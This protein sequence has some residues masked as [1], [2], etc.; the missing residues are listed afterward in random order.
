[1]ADLL[2]CLLA[3]ALAISAKEV[4][5]DLFLALQVGSGLLLLCFGFKI[6]TNLSS[7]KVEQRKTQN[8]ILKLVLQGFSLGFANPLTLI[9][10]LTLFPAFMPTEMNVAD[11]NVALFYCSAVVLSGLVALL[12]YI[13]ASSALCKAGFG[14]V[15]N[16]VSG[17]GLALV[18][19]FVLVNSLV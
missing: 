16:L 14:A 1:V 10:F 8:S 19:G 2:W 12:P 11:F 9:F 5:P 6:I 3:L 18:G 4:S 17:V 13:L 7:A 15:L